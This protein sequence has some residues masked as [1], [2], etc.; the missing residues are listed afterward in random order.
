MYATMFLQI[1]AGAYGPTKSLDTKPQKGQIELLSSSLA[2]VEFA[3]YPQKI[4]DLATSGKI[5]MILSH[6]KARVYQFAPG[7]V[8]VYDGK[9]INLK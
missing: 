6:S 8:A 4:P 7:H 2:K 1:L 3:L 5:D 9:A